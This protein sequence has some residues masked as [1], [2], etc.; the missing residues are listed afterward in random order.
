VV[1]VPVVAASALLFIVTLTVAIRSQRARVDTGKEGLIG[2][3]GTAR[4]AV[5]RD[6]QVFVRGEYWNAES[7]EPIEAGSHVTV[8]SVDGLRLKVKRTD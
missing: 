4:T 5:H 3:K 2:L 8:L 1:I 6:G 7:D